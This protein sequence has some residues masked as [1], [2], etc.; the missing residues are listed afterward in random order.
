MVTIA[1]TPII[2]YNYLTCS[3]YVKFVFHVCRILPKEI[4]CMAKC[5]YD[6]MELTHTNQILWT[7]ICK[8]LV[9][10]VEEFILI[11]LWLEEAHR[12]LKAKSET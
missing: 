7:L 4:L 12:L 9:K 8:I 11:L 6:S 3:E 2:G 5:D 10:T 1:I